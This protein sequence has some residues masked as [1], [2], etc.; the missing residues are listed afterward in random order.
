MTPEEMEQLVVDVERRDGRCIVGG[1]CNG[2]TDAHHVIPQR[3]LRKENPFLL[4]S[5]SM[6]V[7]LCDR[8]HA[9]VE[10][11]NIYLDFDGLP[12]DVQIGIESKG[13]KP[14]WDGEVARRVEVV[15]ACL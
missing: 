1:D 10:H 14:W 9:R 15:S 11:H 8:H 4:T 2:Q 3:K 12:P 6:A 5:P 7:A 13:Y